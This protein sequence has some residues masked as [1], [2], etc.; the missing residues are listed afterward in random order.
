MVWVDGSARAGIYWL[1]EA[2]EM[3]KGGYDLDAGGSPVLI[4]VPKRWAA[5]DS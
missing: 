1:I 3:W 4:S 2:G 5:S